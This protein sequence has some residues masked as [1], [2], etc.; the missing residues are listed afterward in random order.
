MF[1]EA[2]L[3]KYGYTVSNTWYGGWESEK[4]TGNK[5]DA[6]IQRIKAE[7]VKQGLAPADQ[8]QTWDDE[9]SKPSKEATEKQAEELPNTII[10]V[11]I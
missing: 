2:W 11:P 3:S 4:D 1:W 8:P 9:A 7:L 10:D 5:V 6:E